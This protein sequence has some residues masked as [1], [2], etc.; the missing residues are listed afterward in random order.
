MLSPSIFDFAEN[1]LVRAKTVQEKRSALAFAAGV[2]M[3]ATD[4][5]EHLYH[6]NRNLVISPAATAPDM[7][8][9]NIKHTLD[10]LSTVRGM[11]A[12]SA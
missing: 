3:T 7:L 8:D 11:V 2:L 5:E 12:R 9:R 6:A 4:D 10:K 1:T